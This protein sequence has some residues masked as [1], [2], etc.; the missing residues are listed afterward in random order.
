MKKKSPQFIVVLVLLFSLFSCVPSSK[1]VYL[2]DIAAS[3]T[4]EIKAYETLLQPDDLLSIIVSSENPENSI[5]FNLP[6]I[7]GNYEIGNNQ[8]G[9]KTYL[10][11][12]D[13]NIDFPVL[14]KIKLAGLSR[15]EADQKLIELLS[16]Y[17]KNPGINLRILNYKISVLGEVN[18]PGSYPIESERITLLEALSK[19]G[20]LTIYGKRSDILVIREING[21]KNY[22]H[23]DITKS[24]F[25][26]SD[27]YY[28]VQNDVVLVNPNRTRQNASAVGPNTSV[29][30]S[31]ISILATIAVVLFK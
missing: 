13:G 3:Q 7:Q 30:L 28:L 22:K 11:D 26:N 21:I 17:I 24:D 1:I 12:S 20:D 16:E 5:P 4:N 31:A 29:I 19:A 25:I 10:V 18:R 9:I 8:N 27:Y 6:Q 15:K 14:G 23:I 2:Q